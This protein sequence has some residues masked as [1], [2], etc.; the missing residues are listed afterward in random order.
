[1]LYMPCVAR[2]RSDTPDMPNLPEEPVHCI[3]LWM[4]SAVANMGMTCDI[5]LYNIEWKLRRAQAHD[6]LQELRK[7]LRLKRHL[8]SFKRVWIRGQRAHMRSRAVID[9]VQLK[10]DAA[11]TKYRTAWAALDSLSVKLSKL[12]WQVEFPKLNNDDIR[13][14]T[15]AQAGGEG[16]TEGRRLVSVS[17]IWKQHHGAGEEELST[18][19]RVEWCKARARANRWAEEVD[20]VQEEMRRVLTYFDWQGRW[21]DERAVARVDFAVQENEALIAYASRQANIRCSMRTHCLSLWSV[22]P[23]LL[24]Q[25]ATSYTT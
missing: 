8:T 9:T 21:W 4:P 6:A 20:L 14:M 11:A 16:E 24:A 2:L 23:G 7:H 12:T 5:N 1:M 10:I 3:K 15:E 13:G 18:A 17:W 19:M 25:S 22:V